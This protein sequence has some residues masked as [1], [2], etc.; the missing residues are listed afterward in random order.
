MLSILK[1][2]VIHFQVGFNEFQRTFREIVK[3][4]SSENYKGVPY[5]TTLLSTSLWTFYGA[6]DP[7]DGVLIV[8][9]NAVG[10]V[11][12]LPTI[13]SFSLLCFQ[14]RESELI[15]MYVVFLGEVFR[16]VVLDLLFL[17]VVIATTL[18]AFHGSARRTFIGVLCATF[19][20][21]MY[22]A[23]LSAVRAVIRTKSVKYMPFLLSFSLL[24]NAAA[25]FTFAMLLKDYYVLVPNA[26]GIVL[27]SLQLIVYVV[28]KKKSSS[29]EFIDTMAD[30]EKLA[31]KA[32]ETQDIEQGNDKS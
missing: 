1:A 10:V 31:N 14:K 27:G 20:I 18:A 15:K 11:S 7:D 19:T 9:V 5:V 13:V 3:K 8:T 25:W 26:V 23:P 17:G 28:Y 12:Q 30:G 32:T 2:V 22:A 6:L 4:K 21:A 16:L 24:V 29:S